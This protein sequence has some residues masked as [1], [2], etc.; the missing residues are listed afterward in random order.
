MDNLHPPKP[1]T[2][3]E[4]LIEIY[5]AVIDIRDNLIAQDRRIR[6][7]EDWQQSII[8]TMQNT[9]AVAIAFGKGIG[10]FG[11]LIGVVY[12]AGKIAGIIQ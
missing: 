5:S 12:T 1:Q 8:I 7:L 3:R 2:D 10:L 4:F 11:G 6:R 9:K